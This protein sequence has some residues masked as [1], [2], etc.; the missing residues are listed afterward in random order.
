MNLRT[1]AYIQAIRGPVILVTIGILFAIQQAGGLSFGRSWPLLIIVIG[2]ML[3]LERAWAPVGPFP[4]G[5]QQ[6]F[7]S[8]PP[9]PYQ[10]AYRHPE[11]PTP[12]PGPGGT[13]L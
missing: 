4:Y 8:Y 7:G 12:P 9:P 13:R 1:A 2:V 3:L 5:A 6:D 10:G 11:S